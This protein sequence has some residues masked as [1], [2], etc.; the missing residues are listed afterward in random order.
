MFGQAA[1]DVIAGLAAARGDNADAAR[2]FGAVEAQAERSGLKRDSAD[3]AFVLPLV[4]Q[5]RTALGAKTFDNARAEGGAWSV[6][7]AIE[8]AEACA[9][10]GRR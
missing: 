6:E 10:A 4:D 3:A 7:Q 1:L 2:F 8:R 9:R 5:A